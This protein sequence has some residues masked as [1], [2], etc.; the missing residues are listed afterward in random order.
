MFY[1]LL[2]KL[3]LCCHLVEF[4]GGVKKSRS[5][6]LKVDYLKHG[7]GVNLERD[8]RWRGDG[9]GDC[10]EIALHGRPFDVH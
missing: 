3:N 7:D 6:N 1:S 5:K 10:C 2:F 8:E 9:S 4:K